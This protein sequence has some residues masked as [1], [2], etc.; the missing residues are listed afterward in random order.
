MGRE[1]EVHASGDTAEMTGPHHWSRFTRDAPDRWRGTAG[2]NE[3][4][5]LHVRRD[6]E[7]AVSKL[8]IATFIFSRN[9][10]DLA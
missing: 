9:P 1:Y 2:E 10:F 5:V 4:E 3:G 6:P 8:D 7:G